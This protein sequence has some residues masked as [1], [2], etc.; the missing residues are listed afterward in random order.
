MRPGVRG[1]GASDQFSVMHI[2]PDGCVRQERIKVLGKPGKRLADKLA[3]KITSELILNTYDTK[4]QPGDPNFDSSER[5][6]DD[7]RDA[8]RLG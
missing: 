3:D 7:R 2:D 6:G 4:R 5:S 1:L 8:P